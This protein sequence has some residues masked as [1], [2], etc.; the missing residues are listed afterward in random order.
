MSE[1]DKTVE[2]YLKQF[3]H[4]ADT[5]TLENLFFCYWIHL[6]GKTEKNK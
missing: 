6:F 2:M 4:S 5:K 1:D 3:L